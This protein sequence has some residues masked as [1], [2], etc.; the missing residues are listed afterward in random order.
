VGRGHRHV[1]QFGRGGFERAALTSQG[2]DSAQRERSGPLSA[3]SARRHGTP[4]SILFVL[5]PLSL[6]LVAFAVGA[7]LWAVDSGQFENLERA[8]W[9]ML[10][11]EAEEN[12]A[13]D[14]KTK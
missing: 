14:P 10:K 7:F 4:M 13:L 2:F 11:D 8:S 9:D 6:V 1:R 5:I 12:A 3:G